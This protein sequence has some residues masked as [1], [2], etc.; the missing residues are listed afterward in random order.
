MI[1]ISPLRIERPRSKDWILNLNVYR[2][3]HYMTLNTVKK[4]YKVLV[5]DQIDLLPKL[6]II[7]LELILYPKTH[8]KTDITNVCCIHDKFICD[9]IVESG[10]LQDDD[11]KHIISTTYSFGEVDKVNPRVKIHIQEIKV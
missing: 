2:N 5:Q 1:I 10:K 11:Y 8:R 4:Q 3:A 6:D 9:A 7:R